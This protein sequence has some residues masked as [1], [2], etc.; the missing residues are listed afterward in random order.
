MKVV[1]TQHVKCKYSSIL[2]TS[3]TAVQPTYLKYDCS[4]TCCGKYTKI[5]VD[6]NFAGL[7][8]NTQITFEITA[9]LLTITRLH[10]AL[11]THTSS[12][13]RVL[14]K[15]TL[16][17]EAPTLTPHFEASILWSLHLLAIYVIKVVSF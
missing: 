6:S 4:G 12:Q 14:I 5:V 17:T 1:T 3:Q 2:N 11:I 16:W 7:Y 15:D 10:Q 9:A 13:I 8:Q